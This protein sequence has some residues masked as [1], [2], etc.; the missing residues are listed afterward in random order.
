[1]MINKNLHTKGPNVN[2]AASK[3]EKR[4]LSSQTKPLEVKKTASLKA[5]EMLE[6][7][8]DSLKLEKLQKI[9][10]IQ[11]LQKKVPK[12]EEQWKKIVNEFE[13]W[14]EIL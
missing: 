9:K 12:M 6:K 4:K 8:N 11:K 1:M 2:I 10:T 7:E 3:G 5:L 14:A 13:F